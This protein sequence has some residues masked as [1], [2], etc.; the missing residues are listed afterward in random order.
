MKNRLITTMPII[1][2]ALALLNCLSLKSFAQAAFTGGEG[3]GYAMIPLSVNTSI[4]PADQSSK[5]FDFSVFP[6]PLSSDQILKAKIQG[7]ESGQTVKVTVSDMIGSRVHFEEVES[8]SEISVNLPKNRIKKGIY[9]ITI[10]Y[11]HQKITRR[12]SYSE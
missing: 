8:A 2:I 10:E 9:L 1:I 5:T 3:G 6:N 12:F 7:V 4:P 11:K